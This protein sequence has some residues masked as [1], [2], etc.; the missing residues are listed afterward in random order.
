MALD[1]VIFDLD[2]TLIDTNGLHARAWRQA[3]QA[4]G[5]DVPEDRLILEIGKGGDKL[6]SSVLGQEAAEEEGQAMRDAHGAAYLA[7]IEEVDVQVFPKVREL[8]RAVHERGLKV[9]IATASQK[10]HLERV[11]EEAGLELDG[12]A[13]VVL[14]DDDVENSKPEP[15]VVQAAVRKLGLSPAQCVMVGD[16]PYDA[17]AAKAAGV[18]CLSVQ[19]GVRGAQEMRRAG[20]RATYADPADLLEHLDEA[21][22]LASPG[23]AHLTHDLLEGLME[24]AR[25]EAEAGLERGEIPIG[26][27]IA[28]G[29]GTILARGRNRGREAGSPLAHAELEALRTAFERDPGA[30][31]LLLVSTLEPCLMCL[32]AAIEAGVDTVVYGLE[33]PGNGGAG[34]FVPVEEPGAVM[35]RLVGGVGRQAS[36]R[37]LEQWRETHP[38]DA[39]VQDLLGDLDVQS[40]T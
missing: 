25:E 14:N 16:T 20:M 7:L 39:F 38:D 23:E 9:A 21:L 28:R 10:E 22:A 24:A 2:G 40:Q 37:L 13:D 33:A 31:D 30:R 3:L 17:G 32:G 6:V 8:L 19:T 11:L 15:D 5:Y 1:A 18:V 36:R 34:R 27:V 35:P 4:F 29:D 26:S 12:L